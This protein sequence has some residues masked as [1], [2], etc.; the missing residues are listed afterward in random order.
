MIFDARR[1]PPNSDLTADVC[2]VGAGPIGISVAQ[3]LGRAGLSVILLDAGGLDHDP[4]ANAGAEPESMVFDGVTRL[5]QTRQVGGNANTWLVRTGVTKRGVRLL[6]LSDSELSALPWDDGSGWPVRRSDLESYHRDAATILNIGDDRFSPEDFGTPDEGLLINDSELRTGVFRF[7]TGGR[8]VEQV[9]RD[10]R[11]DP[12]IRLLHHATVVEVLTNDTGTQA[13]GVRI[14]PEPGREL[15][16]RAGQVV[17]ASG[18]IAVTQ[19][20]LASDAVRAGGLGNGSGH[21]GRYFMDHPMV[22]GGTLHPASPAMFRQAALYDM[23]AIGGHP[24]M[25]YLHLTDAVR[26]RD[27]L[28]NLSMLIFPRTDGVGF[29]ASPR[30]DRGIKAAFNIR[31]A[32]IRRRMPASGDVWNVVLGLDGA[33]RRQVQG[34]LNPQSSLGRGGWSRQAAPEKRF[35]HFDVLHQTEEAPH[36]DNRITLGQGRDAYGQRKIAITATW[37]TEDQT[38]TMRA[39]RAFAGALARL[40]WGDYRIADQ[41][42]APVLWSRSSSHFMGT[43]RMN[44]SDRLGVVDTSGA[45]HGTPNVFVA[46]SSIFPR[47]GFGNVTLTALA[48]ALRTADA[49]VAARQALIG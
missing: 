32:M 28:L 47:G 49:M 42:G 19:L 18:C 23:R 14:V 15:I 36:P 29:A 46:S 2:V 40:G 35:T 8:F 24:V 4:V 30:Q 17:L 1:L 43:T 33:I 31:E 3:R 12:R 11:N 38:R 25:G 39:Q 21:L 6:P 5:G 45:V 34:V 20:L 9:V 48:M 10:L 41:G 44:A 13:T 27:D 26:T 37:H 7:G 22:Y 16:V